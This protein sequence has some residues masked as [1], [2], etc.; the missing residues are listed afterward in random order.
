[1]EAAR[2]WQHVETL[3]WADNSVEEVYK[4]KD[5]NIKRV[6]AVGPHGDAC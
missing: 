6:I 5:G 1:M 2:C 3:H 4:D